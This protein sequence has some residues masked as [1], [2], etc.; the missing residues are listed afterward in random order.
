MFTKPLVRP[1]L[2]RS[3]M[4]RLLLATIILTAQFH[5]VLAPPVTAAPASSG[6]TT[7]GDF[8]SLGA[9]TIR[10]LQE[11]I[12]LANDEV[13]EILEQLEQDI[14]EI[15]G[16]LE[17]KFQTNVDYLISGLDA[18]TRNII[19][20]LES[21][22]ATVNELIQGNIE[23][24]GEEARKTIR[25]ASVQVQLMAD[26]LEQTLQ[27]S[28]LF[29]GIT[30]AFLLDRATNNILL[31][32]AIIMLGVGLLV[33]IWLL[34]T[35]RL[36]TGLARAV[37]FSFMALYLGLF[38]ALTVS[39]VRALAMTFTGVGIEKQ[40]ADVARGPQVID[41]RPDTIVL[42]ETQEVDIWG[43]T[44]LPDGQIPA[45]AIAGTA[46][47]VTAAVDNH[48]VVDVASLEAPEGSKRLTLLYDG[49]EGPGAVVTI[50]S[51]EPPADPAELEITEFSINPSSPTEGRNVEAT[52]KVCNRGDSP[53][54]GFVVQWKPTAS[55][56]GLSKPVQGADVGECPETFFPSFAYP[57]PGTFDAIAIVDALFEVDEADDNNNSRTRSITVQREISDPPSPPPP[58]ATSPPACPASRPICCDPGPN[59][60]CRLCVASGQRCP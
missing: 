3:F 25:D 58:T 49:E 24:I 37:A 28:T 50:D 41:A 59:D 54:S 56:P 22:I 16:M 5:P 29:I 21:Q 39:P 53:A 12:E 9:N 6:L 55:H 11:A 38:G 36:P 19:F 10:E 47:T 57:S 20:Q 46:V 15:T 17:Q 14:E 27:R 1:R 23:Q 7:V 40:L 18:A 26:D 31:I 52:V 30:G 13:K 35:R 4:L 8:L 43:S 42:G 44:L 51:P 48:I 2:P 60:T 32:A 33:F 34:Y 45:V